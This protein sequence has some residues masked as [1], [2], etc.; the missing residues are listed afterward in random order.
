MHNLKLNIKKIIDISGKN[1]KNTICLFDMDGTLTDPRKKIESH[2]IKSLLELSRHMKIGIVTGSDFEYVIQQ[3]SDIFNI[4]GVPT[5]MIDI[6]PC[7]GTKHYKWKNTN[8]EILHDVNMIDEIG[9]NNYN[10]ILQ[11]LSAFQMMITLSHDLP[12]TGTF[13]HYRGSMLNWCPIGRQAKD[14]ER[15]EWVKQDIE[16][17]IREYFFD[18]IQNAISDKKIKATVALG[19]S[20]SFDIY[21]TGW[22]K[23]YVMNHLNSYNKIFFIGDRCDEGG[24]DKALYDLLQIESSS[25][26]TTSPDE[27]CKIIEKIIAEV[28]NG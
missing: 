1:M 11:S 9:R 27:T 13:F 8:F 25:F 22:D 6:F 2:M 26:K 12:Y 15:S 14:V 16:K 19:G 10:Y 24:N 23:T 4:G 3:C 5:D 20:T 18:E 28:S 17:G 7:N 21:P